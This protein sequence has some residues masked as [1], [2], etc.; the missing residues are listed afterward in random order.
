MNQDI[1]QKWITA[2]NSD[3][4]SQGRNSLRQI[5]RHDDHGNDYCCLGVLTELYRKETGRGN[6]VRV[7]HTSRFVEGDDENSCELIQP[8]LDWSGLTTAEQ[9]TLVGLNDHH[10]QNFTEIAQYI[11]ENM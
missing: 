8:V 3:E 5:S 1:K 2:L 10:G 11:R 7:G 6:W 4:Y 9:Y